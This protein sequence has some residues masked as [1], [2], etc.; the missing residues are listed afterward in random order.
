MHLRRIAHGMGKIVRSEE[1][2]VDP[3]NLQHLR[4]VRRS[5]RR[6]RPSRPPPCRRGPL[7]AHS[8]RSRRSGCAASAVL[9]VRHHDAA[10]ARVQIARDEKGRVAF[11]PHDRLNA[12]RA[13]CPA[14]V[15]NALDP[16]EPVLAVDEYAVEAETTDEFRER[17]R[18]VI[19]VDHDDDFVA[20]ELLLER[21]CHAGLSRER[22]GRRRGLRRA[23]AARRPR[24]R[25][26][27]STRRRRRSS[28]RN[29]HAGAA[30]GLVAI[31]K[32]VLFSGPG[33]SAAFQVAP[34][35]WLTKSAPLSPSKSLPAPR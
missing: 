15:L 19:G 32:T 30:R 8:A 5:R 13:R 22:R 11:W 27:P 16:R 9:D 6:T 21:V 7:A 23:A 20:L 1:E 2:N 34:S 28:S 31:A 25:R 35:S 3:L 10:R 24:R 14:H 4:Q 33:R 17:R 29:G 26:R 12:R 18:G